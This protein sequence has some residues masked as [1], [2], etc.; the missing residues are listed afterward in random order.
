[1]ERYSETSP[2]QS[3]GLVCPGGLGYLL[4]P[5]GLRKFYDKPA[6]AFDFDA[7]YWE[8][9][10]VPSPAAL[11]GEHGVGHRQR[12]AAHLRLRSHQA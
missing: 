6:L 12:R 3:T 4:V 10:P 7:L 9:T 8:S 5:E 2:F 1:M 11:C